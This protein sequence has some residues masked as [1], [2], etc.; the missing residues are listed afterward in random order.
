[1]PIGQRV[2]GADGG[3]QR[4]IISPD[5]FDRRVAGLSIESCSLVVAIDFTRSNSSNDGATPLHYDPTAGGAADFLTQ[6][7]IVA[8]RAVGLSLSRD[9]L[10]DNKQYPCYAFGTDTAKSTGLTA[11]RAPDAAGR[12]Q[13]C[14]GLIGAES[15]VLPRYVKL[16][17][18][19]ND[20]SIEY[21]KAAGNKVVL[22]GGTSFAPAIYRACEHIRENEG[23]YHILLIVTDGVPGTQADREET[24]AAIAFA[25]RSFPLSILIVG[26]GPGEGEG[27]GFSEMQVL[28]DACDGGRD[29][30]RGSILCPPTH[31]PC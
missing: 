21:D 27:K 24:R 4:L 8:L 5:E 15:A 30:V 14:R 7:Y 12:E 22:S 23:N 28:D 11:F 17:R 9:S 25:S 13:E 20:A 26:V 2:G 19:I 10:D 18:T 6:P 3:D 16:V 1:M 29:I 31:P